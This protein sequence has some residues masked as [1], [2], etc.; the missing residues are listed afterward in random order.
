MVADAAE[1]PLLVLCQHGDRVVIVFVDVDV[2]GAVVA[3][4]LLRV[5]LSLLL[6][7][8]VLLEPLLDR[9]GGV[10]HFEWEALL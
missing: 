9:F 4:R 5:A 2:G 1:V 10:R 7:V 8:R 6:E 3:H